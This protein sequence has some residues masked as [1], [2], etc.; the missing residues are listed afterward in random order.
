MSHNY[1]GHAVFLDE[2]A[3]TLLGKWKFLE[4]IVR[5][6]KL[7]AADLRVAF[8]LLDHY[9]G[10]TGACYPGAERLAKKS[11]LCLRTVKRSISRL[12]D[13]ELGWFR[14]DEGGG[15]GRANEYDPRFEL[16]IED[17]QPWP[18]R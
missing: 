12:T 13:P 9:N 17:Y 18:K 15:R 10:E 8:Q 14:V 16:V 11:G 4:L 3:V 7:S 2:S 5:D 6:S 1:D